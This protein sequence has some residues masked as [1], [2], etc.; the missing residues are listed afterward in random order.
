VFWDIAP[1]SLANIYRH[2]EEASFLYRH[3]E[4]C[5]I[6]KNEAL[7]V[8]KVKVTFHESTRFNLLKVVNIRRHRCEEFKSG[9]TDFFTQNANS[10]IEL[11]FRPLM[12]SIVDVPHR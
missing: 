4:Y 10:A 7:R 1:C 2:F 6:L 9:T 12:S 5:L 8:S 3:K 11:T